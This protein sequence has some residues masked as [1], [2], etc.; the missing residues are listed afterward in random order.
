MFKESVSVQVHFFLANIH[1]IFPSLEKYFKY[2][3][4]RLNQHSYTF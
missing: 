4:G 2:F 3:R 1:D